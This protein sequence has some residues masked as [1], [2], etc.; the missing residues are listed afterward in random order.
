MGASIWPL[1]EHT[2][3]SIQD[4]RPAGLGVT[5]DNRLGR[6]EKKGVGGWGHFVERWLDYP[7]EVRG[8]KY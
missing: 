4:T 1:S 2:D 6:S 5:Q 3:M 7:P 8:G